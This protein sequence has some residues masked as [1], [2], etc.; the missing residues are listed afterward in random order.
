MSDI[1]YEDDPDDIFSDDDELIDSGDDVIIINEKDNFDTSKHFT[2]PIL[3]KYER[4]MIIIERTQQLLNLAQPLINN[5]EKYTS[6]EDIVEEELNQ[7][8]IPFIIKRSIGNRYDYYKLSDL[9]IL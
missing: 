5:A 6:I 3:T 4:T 8:K 2:L 7:K 9:E 1:T